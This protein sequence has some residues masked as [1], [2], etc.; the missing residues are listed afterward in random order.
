MRRRDALTFCILGLALVS[1]R[2][3]EPPAKPKL[4][5]FT[6]KVVKAADVLKQQGI[7]LDPDAAPNWL[8]LQTA[9]GKAHPIVKDIG[10]RMF[11]HDPALLG[12]DY[13]IQGRILP[14]TPLLQVVQV[15]G[16]K[17]GKRYDI[18]YWCEVC[19]IKRHA[20]EKTGVC[21]CCG[22]PM[23]RREVELK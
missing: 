8:V 16:L 12:R 6:G 22:G 1:G 23:E 5:T 14:G 20:L 15:A 19:A 10:G 2:S 9:D 17:A 7:E 11:Y 4:E 13:E 18:Y 21:E 3:A